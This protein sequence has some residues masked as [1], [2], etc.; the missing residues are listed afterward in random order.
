MRNTQKSDELSDVEKVALQTQAK[1]KESKARAALRPKRVAGI[2]KGMKIG[3][4]IQSE[5]QRMLHSQDPK[6]K[7]TQSRLQTMLESVY[8][9]AVDMRSGQG[10]ASAELL[11]AYGYE[12]PK[13]AADEL[14]AMARSGLQVV[15]VNRPELNDVPKMEA[16]PEPKPEF[17][18][19]E[20]VEDER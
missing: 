7:L 9:R 3:V 13:P 14:D 10:K 5:V 17:I 15:F 4:Y 1:V 12:K 20:I 2:P 16:L 11:L 8:K 6:S 19:A 18:N